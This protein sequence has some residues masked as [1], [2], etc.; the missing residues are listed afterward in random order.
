MSDTIKIACA[1]CGKSTFEFTAGIF[2]LSP[3][4]QFTCR[5]CGTTLTIELDDGVL[6]V[7]AN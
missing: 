7:E 5:E 6:R 4:V 2:E 1:G 3:Q